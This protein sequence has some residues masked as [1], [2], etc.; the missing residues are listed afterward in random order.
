MIDSSEGFREEP[1]QN[2][3]GNDD[4]SNPPD[5]RCCNHSRAN[6]FKVALKV[7]TRTCGVFDFSQ[8]ERRTH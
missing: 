5:F 4:E 6:N 2:D 1:F 8:R 3:D 7:K